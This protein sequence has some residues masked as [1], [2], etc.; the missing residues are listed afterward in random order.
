MT[1]PA[2]RGRW[3]RRVSRTRRAIRETPIPSAI[4][5]VGHVSV[6]LAVG[7]EP[8]RASSRCGAGGS[9]NEACSAVT[10]RAGEQ[11]WS[12]GSAGSNPARS[13]GTLGPSATDRTFP[14]YAVLCSAGL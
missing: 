6:W 8:P 14:R 11:L 9:G 3:R 10:A 5:D 12:E 1:T 7:P 2:A 4:S 13:A